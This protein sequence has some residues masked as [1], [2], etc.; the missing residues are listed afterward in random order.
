[1]KYSI[2]SNIQIPNGH[3]RARDPDSFSG[4]LR[5]LK[6]GQSIFRKGNVLTITSQAASILKAGNYSVRSLNGGARVWRI[7]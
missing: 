1:M 6:K 5:A 4:K 7:K 3:G 2:Q